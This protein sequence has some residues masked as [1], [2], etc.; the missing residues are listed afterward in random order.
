MGKR[1]IP[2]GEDWEEA[3]QSLSPTLS[4]LEAAEVIRRTLPPEQARMAL[5]QRDL[6]RRAEGRLANASSLLLTRK[7]LEQATRERVALER[8]SRISIRMPNAL[9]FDATSGIGSDSYALAKSGLRFL[10][11]DIEPEHAKCAR[12]NL[13]RF[14]LPAHVVIADANHPPVK[15]DVIVLDPDR[16]DGSK[17]LADPEKWSPSLSACL[18]LATTVQATCI[19]LAPALDL[20]RIPSLP[21]SLRHSWQW[22]SADGELVEV[23]LWTGELAAIDGERQILCLN[24]DLEPTHYSGTPM[25]DFHM[26]AEEAQNVEWISEPDPALIRSGLL[27]H[28]AQA[29]GLAPIGPSIAYLGSKSQPASSPLIKTWR[30]RASSTSDRKRVRAM[31]REHDIGEL[32]VKKR[33]YPK[34]AAELA[35]EYRGKGSQTGTL[36]VTRLEKGHRAYLVASS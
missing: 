5:E 30:V 23:A 1:P 8:A 35:R 33:G 13:V 9:V 27:T 10:V 16:R 17:R 25:P 28:F 31:L 36:I 26:P 34:T 4:A 15:A 24:D 22:T 21:E 3:L 18:R 19:K 11:A 29:N 32:V 12:T 7:G 14:H 20:D 2:K 6:R